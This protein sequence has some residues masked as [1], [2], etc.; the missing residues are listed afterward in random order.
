MPSPSASILTDIITIC[1][2]IFELSFQLISGKNA[3]VTVAPPPDTP[4]TY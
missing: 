2:N 3:K 4:N 1:I